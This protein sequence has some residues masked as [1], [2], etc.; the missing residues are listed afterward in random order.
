M[1]ILTYLYNNTYII[2]NILLHF[3]DP[4]Q[5][6]KCIIGIKHV[7]ILNDEICIFL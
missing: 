4:G 2:I 5:S 6:E 3:L 1:S 7:L